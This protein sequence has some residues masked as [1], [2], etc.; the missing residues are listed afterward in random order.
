[1]TTPTPTAFLLEEDAALKAKLTGMTVSDDRRA[2]RPVGVW[3]GQP[4]LELR[5]RTF[6]YISIELIDINE[7][8]ERV[9]NGQPHLT[10]TPPGYLPAPAGS[11]NIADWFPTPYDLDY[12]VTV[13]SR[14]PRHDRQIL[15]DL[16]AGRLPMRFGHLDMPETKRIARLDVLGGPQIA[17]TTDENGK[18]LFRKVFTVRVATELFPDAVI[19][20]VGLVRQ[21]RIIPPTEIHTGY[22]VITAEV[23]PA[24]M[25]DESLYDLAAYQ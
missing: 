20:A 12:Q 19:A 3:F 1:M 4:D 21:V 23:L 15:R 14:H 10:Y 13:W 9:M 17:D 22:E 6:P 11:V 5:E 25:Y 24:G 8:Q 7:S 16:L 18:R 2:A